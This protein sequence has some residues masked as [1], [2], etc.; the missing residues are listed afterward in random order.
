[1]LSADDDTQVGKISKQWAGLAK[2][3]LTDADKF[4]ISFPMDL[5]V[6]CKATLLGAVFLIVSRHRCSRVTAVAISVKISIRILIILNIF[7]SQFE[8]RKD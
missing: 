5:D 8:C 2:E 7:L 6:K 4:G 3:L 1:M